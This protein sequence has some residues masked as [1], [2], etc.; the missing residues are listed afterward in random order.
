MTSDWA[1]AINERL[2]TREVFRY[3]GIPLN[4]KGYCK[5]PFH[6]GG[7]EKTPSMFVYP[8]DRGYHCFAC[9]ETGDSIQF[10]QKFFNISFKDACR[11]I[12][13]DFR[14]GL[15]LDGEINVEERRRINQEAYLRRKEREREEQER[16]R[17]LTAYYDA[18]DRYTYFDR[19]ISERDGTGV[20][21]ASRVFNDDEYITALKN[22]ETAKYRL[23]C[24]EA[25]LREFEKKRGA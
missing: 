1:T 18:L 19:V 6:S 23:D 21:T 2:L 22:I 3:Y 13:Q 8:K 5:C 12:N 11:K 24:A 9:G 4:I 7:N 20:E 14:L 10:V 15:P 16:K 17:I 25:D